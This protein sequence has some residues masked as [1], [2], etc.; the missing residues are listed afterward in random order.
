MRRK[1]LGVELAAKLGKVEL[2]GLDLD[3]GKRLVRRAAELIERGR[4]GYTL[5][6]ARKE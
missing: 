6:T 5:I 3:E 1:L 2:G 4:V